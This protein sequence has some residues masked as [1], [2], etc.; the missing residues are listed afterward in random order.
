MTL[1]NSS[2]REIIISPDPAD[3]KRVENEPAFLRPS[4]DNLYLGGLLTIFHSIALAREALLLRNRTLSNYGHDPQWWNGQPI[5]L[6]KIVSI[7]DAHDG[8]TDWDDIIYETQRLVAFLDATERSF[9]SV[10]ALASLKSMSTCDSEGSIGRFLDTW[11]ESA[12]RADSGNQLATVFSSKAYKRP[13][14]V[15]DTPVHKDFFILES[16]V[17]PEHGQTLYDALD[18]A[19]WADRPGEELDDVWL[20]HIGEIFTI[21]LESADTTKPVDVKVPAVFYPDRYLSESR[22]Y[23]RDFRAQKLHDYDCIYRLENL[24]N[25]FSVAKSAMHKG[26]TIRDTLEQT[27]AA[28][29]LTLPKSLANGANGLSLTPEAANE[30]ANRLADELRDVSNKIEDKLRGTCLIVLT[31]VL[32]HTHVLLDQSSHNEER[33]LLRPFVATQKS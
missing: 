32:F 7:Q 20:E 28:V 5:N 11:Q 13:L 9:G 17:E 4:E 27:A 14:N 24:I 8:D 26:L 10:D 31:I 23:S 19:I 16:W 25:R 22:D 1:F 6:P 30:E 2:A 3:R 18:R 33:A 15:Y 29:S 12:V 21:K